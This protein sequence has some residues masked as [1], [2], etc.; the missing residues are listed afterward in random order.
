MS[1]SV[2]SSEARQVLPRCSANSGVALRRAG[3]GTRPY[4]VLGENLSVDAIGH[5]APG[6]GAQAIHRCRRRDV[7]RPVIV[8]SPGQV[9]RL[10]RHLD[11][12]QMMA[13]GV[14]HPDA[15][16]TGYKEIS[17]AV[18]FDSVGYAFVVSA[19]LLAEDPAIAQR[20]VG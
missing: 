4:V 19:G 13:L 18:N 7:Q 3:E 9:G 8:V 5:E 20:P 15:F 11:D 10:L 17:L 1:P 14:P 6:P 12:A 2:R 16:G